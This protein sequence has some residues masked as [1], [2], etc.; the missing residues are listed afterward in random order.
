MNMNI[1]GLEFVKRVIEDNIGIVHVQ[2][3]VVVKFV[4]DTIEE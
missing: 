1:D 4:R 3:I 2:N